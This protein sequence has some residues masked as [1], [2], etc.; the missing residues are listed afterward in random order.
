MKKQ[1][2][3]ID[4][5]HRS[6]TIWNISVMILLL[7]FPLTVA[8]LFGAAPDWGALESQAGYSMHS[9]GMLAGWKFSNFKCCSILKF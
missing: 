4:S 8:A 3:Y 5:V 1:L 7:A 9:G 2:S 6:G